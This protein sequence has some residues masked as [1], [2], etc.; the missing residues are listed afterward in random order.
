MLRIT[1]LYNR[2]RIKIWFGIII[3]IFIII[4]VNMFIGLYTRKD[5][6]SV[7]KN[8]SQTNEILEDQSKQENLSNVVVDYEEASQSITTRE[9]ID[10]NIRNEIQKML[11][12][13][14]IYSCNGESEKAYGLLTQDC[15]KILYPSLETFEQDYCSDIRGKTYDFQ[16]WSTTNDIYVY[17]V[18]FFDN[19]LTTGMDTTNNY[20]QD[21]I[22][23][24]KEKEGYRLNINKFI[25]KENIDKE[26]QT[27]DIYIKVKNVET[28]FDYEYYELEI[29]NRRYKQVILDSLSEDNST[30]VENENGIKLE[31]LL[32]ENDEE[33]LRV[34]AG[35][36]KTIKIKFN[37][38]Y[39]GERKISKLVFSD[40][41][42]DYDEHQKDNSKGKIKAEIDF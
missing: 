25:K 15:K 26:I 8:I 38:T 39:S 35:E 41:I 4:L 36:V 24:I 27:N 21:Y 9:G 40:I 31:A 17:Q 19:P 5:Y 20:I 29:N 11:E 12:D 14:I 32:Y 37:N 3:V 42:I 7:K 6:E 28:Y 33:E 22:T 34:G 10:D 1:R 30:Y 13:F 23:I 18:R 16:A 2:N